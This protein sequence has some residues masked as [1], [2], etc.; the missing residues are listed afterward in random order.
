MEVV[1]ERTLERFSDQE[2]LV[3]YLKT[4]EKLYGAKMA[5]PELLLPVSPEV[6]SRLRTAVK[7][8][9]LVRLLKDGTFNASLPGDDQFLVELHTARIVL[10]QMAK[11]ATKGGP[12]SV[13]WL[14]MSGLRHVLDRYSE[15]S[16]QASHA[17]RLIREFVDKAKAMLHKSY[18]DKALLVVIA[19]NDKS[20]GLIRRSRSLLGAEPIDLEEGAPGA[21][22]L[23]AA[24]E[25]TAKDQW[26]L[27]EPWSEDFHVAFAIIAFLLILFILSI[28]GISVGIWFM[29]PGRDSI[30][31]RMTSQRMKKD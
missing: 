30:I 31:Y 11:K 24:Q 2:P 15:E 23:A 4:G 14:R 17:L 21:L 26:N 12:P 8:A 16:Y 5:Y 20:S 25:L 27:A 29:D 10:E 9:D 6:D 13:V 7:D 22:P 3:L 1:A 19:Q 18:G 28:F